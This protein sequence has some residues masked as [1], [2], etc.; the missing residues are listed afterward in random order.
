MS[1]AKLAEQPGQP[2]SG[3]YVAATCVL[4]LAGLAALTLVRGASPGGPG[5]VT[6]LL[7]VVMYGI[8]VLLSTLYSGLLAFWRSAVLLVALAM[9]VAAGVALLVGLLVAPSLASDE[10]RCCSGCRPAAASGSWRCGLACTRH[11]LARW[12]RMAAAAV[13]RWHA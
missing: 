12:L 11:T 5:R 10:V 7:A 2:L 9:V 8:M 13:C 3:G 6:G 4:G 1:L